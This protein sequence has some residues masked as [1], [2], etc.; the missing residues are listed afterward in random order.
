M[1]ASTNASKKLIAV[2][3]VGSGSA[4]VAILM[5]HG[6]EPAMVIASNRVA[7][8]YEERSSDATIKGIIASL[9]SAGQKTLAAYAASPH[10][11]LKIGSV[12]AIIRA[13]WT[14]SKTERASNVTEKDLKITNATI[15][16]LAQQA[17]AADTTLDRG[18]LFE[19]SVVRVELNGY[20]TGSPVGKSAHN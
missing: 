6:D 10:K 7:L 17:I 20:P 4:A 19:S 15:G 8:P 11:N 2:A 14:R 16:A 18:N 12:Y 9:S 5:L 13:P 3:D 1:F